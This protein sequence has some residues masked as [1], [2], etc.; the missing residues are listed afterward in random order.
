MCDLT[1]ED[2]R[3]KVAAHSDRL[4]KEAP[5][6]YAAIEPLLK[7][8]DWWMQAVNRRMLKNQNTTTPK[9]RCPHCLDSNPCVCSHVMDLTR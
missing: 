6:I 1:L 8:L 7:D 4:R 5:R 3:A 2:G 9:R